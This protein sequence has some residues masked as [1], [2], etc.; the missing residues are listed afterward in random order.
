MKKIL[1]LLLIICLVCNTK[2]EA[3]AVEE[4]E[5]TVFMQVD[6]TNVKVGDTITL[7]LF[8]EEQY[9]SLST[10]F[11]RIDYD[12]EYFTLDKAGSNV[13]NITGEAEIIN[14][15]FQDYGKVTGVTAND[16]KNVSL[17][18]PKGQ[19]AN[20]KFIATKAVEE[21]EF[22]VLK[23]ELC[24]NDYEI[25]STQCPETS[26]KVHVSEK[27]VTPVDEVF[28]DIYKTW[29]TEYVQYVYDHGLMTGIKGTTKFEPNSN[30]T[31][32]Q[33]AQVLYNM[34]GQPEITDESVFEDLKDVLK[35]QWYSAA[36]AWAYSTGVVTGDLD[37]KTFSPG[38]DVTREQLALMMFRYAKYKGYDTSATSDFAGLIN[39]EKV[40]SWSK[41]GM[42][43]AVGTGLISGVEN[44]GVK[45]LAPQGK[46]SRAQMAAI[47]QRFAVCFIV[48]AVEENI[49]CNIKIDNVTAVSGNEIT[50]PVVIKDNPGFTNFAVV[51]DYDHN[52]LELRDIHTKDD[53]GSYLCGELTS[54]NTAW[55]DEDGKDYGYITSAQ[56]EKMTADGILF[57]AS[58]YVKEGFSGKTSI[59]PIV[60]YMRN[61]TAVFSV[62]ENVN[63]SV[64]AGT[65][66]SGNRDFV[67]GDVN[68]DLDI[69]PADAAR[70]Y[71]AAL[72][73][74]QLTEKEKLTA[75]ING[76]GAITTEDA[77][78]IFEMTIGK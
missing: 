68:G 46:A 60:K 24:D 7:S 47:L 23:M 19:I 61:H 28:S 58:F 41:E 37:T 10:F 39:V 77:D 55:Q 67:I 36:V 74:I 56:S 42:K 31:K 51:L 76:D 75:D 59:T 26:V 45:D 57:T 22:K 50:V 30:I 3:F 62:F 71:K 15:V 29:Y 65:V 27:E 49:N 4:T 12:E 63:T 20:F 73:K 25:M 21:A 11:I 52:C 40:S 14:N 64:S 8:S 1:I 69:T 43:W 17:N 44:G 16:L 9:T 53:N 78:L 6:D 2:W 13:T 34:E 54:V 33:V 32:S 5:Q 18:I 38:A 35:N 72:G 70:G 48:T 66:D